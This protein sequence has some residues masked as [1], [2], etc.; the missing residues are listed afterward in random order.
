MAGRATAEQWGELAA[1]G[2]MVQS[3]APPPHGIASTWLVLDT[4]PG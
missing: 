2:G 4:T 1:R 3:L